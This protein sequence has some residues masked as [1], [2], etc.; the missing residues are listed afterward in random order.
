MGAVV[1][2]A[3]YKQEME[4]QRDIR[5]DDCG[6]LSAALVR[7]GS[8]RL[9]ERCEAELIA[10]ANGASGPGAAGTGAA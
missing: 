5:C 1:E 8:A 4:R 2:L 7:Y 3:R 9:C 10:F 6:R